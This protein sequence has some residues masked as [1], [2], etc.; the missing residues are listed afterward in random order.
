MTAGEA[1]TGFIEANAGALIAAA[2]A[3]GVP[4][5]GAAAAPRAA[6]PVEPIDGA[7]PVLAALQATV[8]AVEVAEG[9]LVR[10]GQTVAILEAM[11]MEHVV[12]APVSGRVTRIAQVRG[13]VV[14]KGDAIV[15][16]APEAVAEVAADG[17]AAVDPDHIRPDLAEVLDR[18]RAIGDDARPE[19]VA[20]RRGRSQ[21]TA[22]ENIADLVDPGSFLE[23]GAFALAAQRRRRS[24]EELLKMSPADGLI[25]GVGAVNGAHFAPE[26][27]RCAALAYDFTVLAGTQGHMNH[28]KTDRLL[29]IVADQE[30]P[31]VWFAEGG[32]GRPGD[33]D[34]GGASGL[35]TP[36][37]KAFAQLAGVVP[38]I[39]VVSG[40][41]FAGNAAFAGMS[42]ILICT[43]KCNIG[44]GGPAMI[45]GGG[46]GVFA[47]EDIG[48]MAVQTQNGVVDILAADEADATR[49][50]K[51]ALSYFQGPL[52]EWTAADQRTLRRAVPENRLRVYEVRGVIETLADAGSFLELRGAFAPGLIAGFVRIEGR[53]MGL[54]A[55]DPK[56]LGG[57]VDCDGADKGSRL[58]QLCDAFDLP[59]LSL[60]DT[61]GFMVGQDSEAAAAVRKTS[62]LFI[63]A[64]R[65]G[66]PMFA[67]VLRK[68]Y[69]LGAQAMAGGSTL[70]PVFCAAWPT[71]EF[72]G[73][74]LEGAVRLAWRRE[75]E[76]LEGAERQALYDKLLGNLYAAGKA[77]HVAA[78]LEI[79]AVIDPADTRQWIVQGLKT[80][81]AR[82]TPPRRFVDAW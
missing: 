53:P 9:D 23:Y 26:A 35:S 60:I 67:V 6:A 62:R 3:F 82:R 70:A 34:G 63:N 29:E 44:M 30:L 1:T 79:D 75:L 40:R 5:F 65:L 68:A 31:L 38:K 73:M 25:C 61:P 69:G 2:A 80:C 78:M 50:A 15:F 71:G 57:A 32:G 20:R 37:F 42:E 77:S 74:G 27:A 81:K 76:A 51:Q 55:N 54:I 22:R 4:D 48:P 28:R 52:P 21:R 45:E 17:G 16:I 39:A 46:L 43:A 33:T 66:T 59:V 13:A 11:K 47:P 72:G 49:L 7:L 58:L 8:G 41:C 18:W 36:S 56:H 12:A 24:P 64:A 14:M 19:A 10:E